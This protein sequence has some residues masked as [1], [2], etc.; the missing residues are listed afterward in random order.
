MKASVSRAPF[1]CRGVSVAKV[2]A[3]QRFIA[4][5]TV[6][7]EDYHQHSDSLATFWFGAIVAA[8][9]VLHVSAIFPVFAVIL[10]LSLFN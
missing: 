4:Y 7:G 6:R 5:A 9:R 2:S 8:S 10:Y 1:Y 3:N